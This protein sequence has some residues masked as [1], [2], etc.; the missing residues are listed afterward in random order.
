MPK[1]FRNK[2]S[3][4]LT[5]DLIESEAFLGLCKSSMLCLI[6]FHQKA[7]KRPIKHKKRGGYEI[8]N[9]GEIIFTYSEARELG[10]KSNRTIARAFNQL[11][12]K[13]FVDTAEPGN[14]YLK[15]PTKY[16]ISDRW[17]KYN[18][19]P[20]CESKKT[21]PQFTRVNPIEFTRGN[22]RS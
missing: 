20:L 15:Q 5:P 21:K 2:S 13:G 22:P 6:R 11:I 1:K 16:S 3:C 8:T 7:F 4:W 18:T 17:K 14:W 12:E 10:L 19:P 9:N